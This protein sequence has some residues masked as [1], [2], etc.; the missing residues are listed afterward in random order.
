MAARATLLEQVAA[1]LAEDPEHVA[2]VLRLIADPDSVPARE[3]LSASA[4]RTN[5]ERLT[6]A[7]AEFMA[8]A[9]PGAEVRALLGGISRQALHQRVRNRRLV[10]LHLLN[11][12]WFPSWQFD[13]TGVRAGV[14]ELLEVLPDSALAADRVMQAPLAEENGRSPADLLSAG[15][16]ARALHYART[17]GG[18]R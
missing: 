11:T 8:H 2:P 6:A 1:R 15:D 18:E 7:R 4:L 14:A 13:E 10:A 9:R 17:A 5:L 12:S 16:L 3:G